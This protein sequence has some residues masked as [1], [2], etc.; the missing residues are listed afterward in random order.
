MGPIEILLGVLAPVFLGTGFLAMGASTPAEF[1]VARIGFA[2]AAIDVCGLIIWWLYKFDYAAWK[3]VVGLVIFA[4]VVIALP[5]ILKWIDKKEEVATRKVPHNFGILVPK[6]EL[7]FSLNGGGRIPFIQIG[8]SNIIFG[9]KGIPNIQPLNEGQGGAYLMPAL[10]ESQFKVESIEGKFRISTQLANYSG[11]WIAEIIR[12]EW[13]VA[14]P[15]GTWD[16]NYSDDSLEVINMQGR[17][18]LQVKVLPDRIQL[19]GV[20]PAGPEWKATGARYIGIRQNPTK[21]A[22]A[23]FNIISSDTVPDSEWPTISRM[24]KYP[25]DTISG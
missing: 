4:L 9:P 7:V 18:V 14:P 13:R 19:Q 10:N 16:R 23:Q 24:F 22:E 20:W 17:V 25:S 1:L 21:P 11:N 5:T 3:Y 12:N 8:N 15:P 2:L 6:S